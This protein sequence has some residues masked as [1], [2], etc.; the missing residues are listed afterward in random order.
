M[1]IRELND[2]SAQAWDSFVHDQMRAGD[3][4]RP[5]GHFFHLSGWS[6]VI[7]KGAGQRADYIYAEQ[8]G[9]IVGVMPVIHRRSLLFG[10][11]AHSIM[12]G[13]YGG[14]CAIDGAIEKALLDAAWQRAE[15]AGSPSLDVRLLSPLDHDPSPEWRAVTGSSTFIR[16]LA[17]DSEA[18]LLAIP[19]KQRAVV[20]K[21][22]K[23]NLMVE[24]GRAVFDRF[25][26][27]Y[28]ISVRNLGTPVFPKK[29]LRLMM[30]AFGDR[31]D[32]L[33]VETPD[34]KPIAS[35]MTFFSHT[36]VMPFYAGG[37][38][39]ARHYGAHDFMYF[40]LM[41]E[42]RKR[43][44]K[45]FDFGRSRND[46]GPY[47]FKKNWG[48]DPIELPYYLRVAEGEAAPNLDAKSG[49]FAKAVEAWKKLPLPIANLI[50]PRLSRHLG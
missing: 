43:G 39:E 13:V 45:T 14:P 25:Y 21:A 3:P 7:S 40:D 48:F 36:S 30:D 4:L 47:K 41:S 34:G 32:V 11:G 22:L 26:S 29:L 18:E 19:R 50:G 27:L 9:S 5:K 15:K 8:D 37:L 24:R 17:E 6:G 38:P 23:N 33:V 16:P 35:C 49:K 42:G 44:L 2:A 28:A 12:F 10:K 20:R 1:Q 46:S 31:V